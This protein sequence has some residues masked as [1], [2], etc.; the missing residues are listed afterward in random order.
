MSAPNSQYWQYISENCPSLPDPRIAVT[1]HMAWQIPTSISLSV[2]VEPDN[3]NFGIFDSKPYDLKFIQHQ[4]WYKI[5][6]MFKRKRVIGWVSLYVAEERLQAILFNREMLK[7]QPQA[8]WR[9]DKAKLV[10]PKKTELQ[11]EKFHYKR[12]D[13]FLTTE[14]R[15]Y[16]MGYYEKLKTKYFD[17]EAL[18]KVVGTPRGAVQNPIQEELDYDGF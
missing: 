5:D 17:D 6:Q 11:R 2:G 15:L 9:Y 12:T 14:E 1:R 18:F 4:C 7:L 13:G 8:V 3:Y 16:Q 10:R